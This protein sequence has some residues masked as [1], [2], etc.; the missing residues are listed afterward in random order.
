MLM[1]ILIIKIRLNMIINRLRNMDE[2]LNYQVN[3]KL[4]DN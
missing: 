2:N 3:R 4:R 1:K